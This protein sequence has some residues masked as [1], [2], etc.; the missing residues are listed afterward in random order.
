VRRVASSAGLP[1][2]RKTSHRCLSVSAAVAEEAALTRF[3]FVVMAPNG[4]LF[5]L[6]IVV[7]H[8]HIGCKLPKGHG[9]TDKAAALAAA[10]KQRQFRLHGNAEQYTFVRF[11][12]ESHSGSAKR[13]ST[14]CRWLQ[15]GAPALGCTGK[16]A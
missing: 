12:V 10:G 8:Q 7:S 6:D 14:S 1:P 4:T 16:G 13:Q 3:Y 2:I 11:A 9:H 15:N 5:H